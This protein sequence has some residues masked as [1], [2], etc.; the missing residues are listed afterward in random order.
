[1]NERV[2]NEIERQLKIR[3]SKLIQRCGVDFLISKNEEN[4]GYANLLNSILNNI[5]TNKNLSSWKLGFTKPNSI[6]LIGNTIVGDTFLE[7]KTI[8]SKAIPFPQSPGE[9]LD[10]LEMFLSKGRTTRAPKPEASRPEAK[11]RSKIT[12]PTNKT[13]VKAVAP[14]RPRPP[15]RPIEELNEE[16]LNE[17]KTKTKA[18]ILWALSCFNI[19]SPVTKNY[20]ESSIVKRIFTKE[21]IYSWPE[22]IKAQ[23]K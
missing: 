14:S 12:S 2:N 6:V 17:L 23:K 19:D 22:F 18:Q 3:V 21:E 9:L 5:L 10:T 16:E 4:N 13:Y 8:V 15:S 1:M 7:E 20:I 11:V